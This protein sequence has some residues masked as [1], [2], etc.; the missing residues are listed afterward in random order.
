MKIEIK[1][2][3]KKVATVRINDTIVSGWPNNEIVWLAYAIFWEKCV[4]ILIPGELNYN[5]WVKTDRIAEE[6]KY[7][8]KKLNTLN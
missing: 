4:N 1:K 8:R 2:D 5:P 6:I 3:N 7:Y